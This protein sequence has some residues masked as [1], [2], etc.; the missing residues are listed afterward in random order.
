MRSDAA[1]SLLAIIDKV[2]GR[3]KY[4]AL[5]FGNLDFAVTYRVENGVPVPEKRALAQVFPFTRQHLNSLFGISSAA[6]AYV[7]FTSTRVY[8]R[9][10]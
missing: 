8:T 9:F 3:F 5:P 2:L 1:A 6:G 10:H 7:T 4:Q